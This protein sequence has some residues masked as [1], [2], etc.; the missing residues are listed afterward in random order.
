MSALAATALVGAVVLGACS[1]GGTELAAGGGAGA[2]APSTTAVAAESSDDTTGGDLG[3]IING[4]EVTTTTTAA[5]ETTTTTAAPVTM[6]PTT[7]RPV[8]TQPPVTLPPTTVPAPVPVAP[9]PTQ[10]STNPPPTTAN[11]LTAEERRLVDAVNAGLAAQGRPGLTP[12]VDLMSGARADANQMVAQGSVVSP[13]VYQGTTRSWS[14]IS[15]SAFQGAGLDYVA[16]AAG[17]GSI[18]AAVPSGATHI[19]VG[20]GAGAGGQAFVSL[21]LA[22][23]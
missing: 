6:P 17:S 9:P 4:V 13:A 23:Q 3:R 21:R 1:S 12:A 2:A 5:P 15:G 19:G 7:Q 20:Y 14:V 16:G 22:V 10:V 18:V 11:D 8:V